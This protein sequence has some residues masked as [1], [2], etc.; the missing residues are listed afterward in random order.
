MHIVCCGSSVEAAIGHV[1][2]GDVIRLVHRYRG[3]DVLTVVSKEYDKDVTHPLPK[4][5]AL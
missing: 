4:S 5:I 2:G 1:N 3:N